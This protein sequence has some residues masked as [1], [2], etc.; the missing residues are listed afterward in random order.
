M[1]E[2]NNENLQPEVNQEE[3]NQASAPAQP[4]QPE[5]EATPE[6]VPP[7]NPVEESKTETIVRLSISVTD[8][9]LYLS[10]SFN[11]STATSLLNTPSDFFSISNRE[12]III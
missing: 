5:V 9:A 11:R 7:Q 2:N 1:Q 10:G 6:N 3:L 12:Y 4:T 8:T